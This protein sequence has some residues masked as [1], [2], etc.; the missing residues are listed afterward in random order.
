M[1]KLDLDICLID[2]SVVMHGFRARMSGAA[3]E[4]F[5]ANPVLLFQHNRPSSY[6]N[7]SDIVMPIGKWNDIRVEGNKLLAKP[8]F[9]DDDPLAMKVQRKVEKGYLNAASVW[10]DPLEISEDVKDMLPGQSLPT[11]TKWNILEASIVDIPNCKNALAIR[12]GAGQRILL[13]SESE[14]DIKEFLKT[15]FSKKTNTMDKKFLCALLGLP[16][17]ATEET[18]SAAVKKMKLAAGESATKEEELTALKNKVVE[19]KTAA[20]T[21]RNEGLVN[22]GI[23]ERKILPGQ[24]EHYLKLAAM[25]YDTTAAVIAELPVIATVEEQL[26]SKA[27]AN[28]EEVDELM[29]LSGKEL[30]MKGKLERLQ[31][32]A[33]EDQFKLKYQEAFGVEFK[34]AQK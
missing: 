26:N 22:Q 14:G 33:G 7:T 13:S 34:G 29:K 25:D 21:Q 23:A 17:D 28:K 19:L 8:E 15:K 9:D 3:L 1:A 32:I 6:S 20:D 2:D 18:I 5:K 16:E 24:K 10:I 27:K 31:V 30:Y 11:F 12:N 4:D